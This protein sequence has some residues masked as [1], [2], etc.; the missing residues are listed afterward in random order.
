M[1]KTDYLQ[2][3]LFEHHAIRG[4]IVILRDVFQ[5]ITTQRH[6]PAP[7]KHVLG[8]AIA[9]TA[10][11][12]A[13]IKYK[14]SLIL[15]AETTG[16]VNLLVVQCNQDLTLRAL[17]KWQDD[18][19]FSQR[20][21]GDGQLVITISPENTTECFQGI[22]DLT[23]DNLSEN[24]ES[25]FVQ[26]EQLPTKLWLAANE[27]QVVGLLLQ[28]MPDINRGELASGE[29]WEYWEHLKMLAN[30]IT[31]IELLSL[32]PVTILQRLFHEEDIRLFDK[33]PVVFRCKCDKH[34]MIQVLKIMGKE[35]AE[36]LLKTH[37]VVEVTCDF[38][39]NHYA[40]NKQE[41]LDIFS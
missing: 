12:S 14:G 34:K 17:A 8:Q 31:D 13:T 16:P 41:V 36:D 15:Q 23:S 1:L 33:D 25:Y 10:L 27:N 7:V 22:I 28:K 21:L 4:E 5:T 32:D 30:T 11:L 37:H 35:E 26:S 20:I 18:A 29:E 39:N 24:L 2:R 19:D 40:F 38:C 3:F 9:A 6:Y